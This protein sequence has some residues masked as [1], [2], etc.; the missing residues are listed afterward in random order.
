MIDLNLLK[1]SDAG[2]DLQVQAVKIS[3]ILGILNIKAS[4]NFSLHDASRPGSFSASSS[5]ASFLLAK[6][7]PDFKDQKQPAPI[8]LKRCFT[9]EPENS[10]DQTLSTQ[11]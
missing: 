1:S 9:P 6:G 8:G 4:N 5:G 10:K 2:N 11:K 7:N 3:A